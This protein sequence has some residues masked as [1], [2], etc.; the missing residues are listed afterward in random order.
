MRLKT[1]HHLEECKLILNT[2]I[3]TAKIYA[4]TLHNRPVYVGF[5]IRSLDERFVEHC[6]PSNTCNVLARAIKKY[7]KSAFRIELIT[8]HEDEEFALTVLEPMY[9]ATYGTS[10]KNGGYNL[11]DG[12]EGTIGFK[13]SKKQRENV[14]VAQKKR[15]ANKQEVDKV[16]KGVQ[17]LWQNDE[18]RK[19]QSKSHQGKSVSAETRKKLSDKLKAYHQAK[20]SIKDNP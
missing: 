2:R 3:M 12:G 5:T 13:F 1:I 8:E 4:I 9:I 16:R 15:F 20:K 6:K 11:S 17:S 14:S 19:R 7:G 10:V 18:Y